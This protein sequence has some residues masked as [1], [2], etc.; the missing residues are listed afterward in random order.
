MKFLLVA[1]L[2]ESLINFRGPLIKA[3]QASGYEVHVAAPAIL[4]DSDVHDRLKKM[5]VHVHEIPLNRAGT[6]FLNDV[7]TLFYLWRLMIRTRPSHVLG[8]TIKPVIYGS[9]AAFFAGVGHR[10]ALI[11]G[12]G[13][14]FQGGGQRN[15]LRA[16]V[17]KLYRIALS[18]V[19]KVFFQ[20]PDDR[21]LFLKTGILN[22]KISSCV[23]NGSGVDVSAF[24]VVRFPEGK[25]CF[26]LIARLLGDK[27][28]REYVHAAKIVKSQ[29][30]EIRF[31]LVGWI[32]VNPDSVRQDELTAWIND[33]SIE[34]LGRLVDVRPAIEA[35]SVFVLPSYREGTPRTVLEA[36][37]M[38][39]PIITTDAPGC[40]ETVEHGYNGFLVPVK[41]VNDLVH[42]MLKFIENP[43][44]IKT[45]GFNSRQ[46]AEAKYD[47]RVVSAVMVDEMKL[48]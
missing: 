5:G 44:L 6:S 9:L 36:M 45:M 19:H 7:L 26:L 8:Y 18:R 29:Y 37:S 17:I 47:A 4:E 15:V 20:N 1:G 43:G 48:S 11:T 35:C 30:P 16:L 3:I 46:K 21:D 24:Q 34:F 41:S 10:Y 38:G 14:T 12:L 33:G 2:A 27:G 40:R 25:P 28:I 31:M 39:R 42:A 23:V 13:Y 32:D 22:S